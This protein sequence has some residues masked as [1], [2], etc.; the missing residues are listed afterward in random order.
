MKYT[1]VVEGI[2]L[3]RPNRFIAHVL[4]DGKEEIVHVKNTGRCRELLVEGAKVIL[5]DCQ[6]VNTRK[7]RY[8]L[9][10]VYKGD[11]LINMDSQ[12]PNKV[13]GEYLEQMFPDIVMA[14]AETKYNTSRFDWY[15]ETTKKKIFLEVKGVTLETDGITKFPDAPTQRGVKHLR[16]LVECRKAGYEACVVFV[17]QMENM[18]SFSPN[19]EMHPAFGQALRDASMQGVKI[20]CLGCHVKPDKLLIG[21]EIPVIL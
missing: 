1:K 12:A 9:I 8:D 21:Y 20:Y 11:L 13:V 18:T 10:A 5:E 15:V 7:T 6:H 17:V 16:E 4:I 3:R 2:F 19:D 14:R